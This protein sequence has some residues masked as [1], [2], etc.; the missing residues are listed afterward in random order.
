MKLLDR[1]V[2][3]LFIKNYLISLAVL[4]GMYVVMDMV[5]QF[6]NIVTVSKQVNGSGL[7][8]FLTTLQDVG[9]YYFYQCFA[10]F[11]QMSGIIPVVA[12]AFTLRQVTCSMPP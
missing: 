6:N 4:I 10:I 5:L 12:A 9:G 2:L 3:F 7:E 8:T 1:Y 11:T